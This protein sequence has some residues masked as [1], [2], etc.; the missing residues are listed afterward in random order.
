MGQKTF[1]N[2]FKWLMLLF[3]YMIKSIIFYDVEIYSWK[4]YQQEEQTHESYIKWCLGL[5]KTTPD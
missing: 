5:D 3:E 1:M 4:E 2:N